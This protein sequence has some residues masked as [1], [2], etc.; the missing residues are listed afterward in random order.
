MR[1]DDAFT[2]RAERMSGTL[3]IALLI[4]PV[5]LV[6]VFAYLCVDANSSMAWRAE[7]GTLTLF[8]KMVNE[9]GWVASILPWAIPA[10][11]LSVPALGFA[12][13]L[14]S[15]KKER[16]CRRICQIA[17]F[18]AFPCLILASPLSVILFSNVEFLICLAGIGACALV[19]D[20]LTFKAEND[21]E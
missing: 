11:I 21:P 17:G 8:Q 1:R 3:G 12:A 9:N 10:G 14:F 13:Y 18:I 16:K 15:L 6:F 5:A 20:I 2:T 7:S 4:A 19:I